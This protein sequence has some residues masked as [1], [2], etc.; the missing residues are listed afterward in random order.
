MITYSITNGSVLLE[1]SL[2][3]LIILTSL[4]IENKERKRSSTYLNS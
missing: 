3:G 2:H 4:K 1:K